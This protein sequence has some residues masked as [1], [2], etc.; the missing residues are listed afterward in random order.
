MAQSIVSYVD[1]TLDNAAMGSTHK[2]VLAL[3]T[4]AYFFDV[5]DFIIL[6]SLI[7]DMIQSKFAVPTQAGSIGMFQLFGIFLGTVGQGEFTDRFGRKRVLQ[8]AILIYA[9]FTILAAL[10]P[11]VGWLMAGRCIAGIGL[12]AAQPLCFS[13][14]AEFA[15]KAIRGRATAFMQ[16]VGGACVWPIGTAFVLGFREQ[17]GWQGIWI[18]IGI[19]GLAV[20]LFSFLL[21]ESPRW[22]VTHGQGDDAL[23]LL[24]RMGLGRPK[25]RLVADELADIRSDPMGVVFRRYRGRIIAAMICFFAFFTAAVSLGGWLP[26]ILNERG[27]TITKALAVVL[28]MQL[29]FP[30]SS[31]FMMYALEA[32]G[33]IRTSLAAFVLAT[34]FAIAF[35]YSTSA[36]SDLVVL[37]VGF[38]MT[39]F[40]QLAGNS[41]QIFSSEVFPTNARASGFGLAQ[42][43]GRLGAAAN[44]FLIPVIQQNFGFGYVMTLIAVLLAVATIAV[45]QISSET[46]GLSLDTIAPPTR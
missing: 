20:F 24:E 7:P 15:P 32:F 2:R 42:S 35:Y 1:S 19:G 13:Y 26:Q 37:A 41:M 25:E 30:L 9:V 46:K 17:I 36:G 23:N 40:V 12:G 11:S 3:I 6:G 31:L 10:S 21:P 44:F 27:Y 45:T 16:F 29:A 22:M 4:F 34:L 8:A 28:G 5:I 43:G 18:V 33:R 39:F 14:A 38:L